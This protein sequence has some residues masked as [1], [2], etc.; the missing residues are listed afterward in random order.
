M[1]FHLQPIILPSLPR[2]SHSAVIA[3]DI[4]E[5]FSKIPAH[6]HDRVYFF[7]WQIKGEPSFSNYGKHAF[8]GTNGQ[9][10]TDAQR[11][12]AIRLYKAEEN[13]VSQEFSKIS[14][15]NHDRVFFHLWT[16]KGK[17]SFA[18]YGRHAFHGTNGQSATPA[19]K[20]EAIKRCQ[21]EIT[22]AKV[23]QDFAKI[24]TEGRGR[25]YFHLWALK[26]RPSSVP[27]FGR[28]AF[29]GTNGL[30]ATPVEKLAAITAYE[31]ELAEKQPPK[32]TTEQVIHSCSICQDDLGAERITATACMHLFHNDCLA[33]WLK[34]HTTCPTCRHD[35]SDLTHRTEAPAPAVAPPQT[36]EPQI[37]IL[38]LM[39]SLH[40]V[41]VRL[42][43]FR[44]VLPEAGPTP[45]EVKTQ[46]LLR[47]LEEA[48]ALLDFGAITQAAFNEISRKVSEQLDEL[49]E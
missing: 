10:A 23:D 46:E 19:E 20:L 32:K 8:H 22:Q 47:R 26:G 12:E 14:A 13:T 43:L 25:V 41:P 11:R 39:L 6:A 45:A 31:Q 24:P 40:G 37:Q 49:M 29:H 17:P 33:P 48:R 7:M 5:A 2:A 28:H 3:Y 30:N 35:I 21:D 34:D 4:L 16:L 18:D 15:S 1:S 44:L 42:T 27:D 9:S 38:P 36:Q